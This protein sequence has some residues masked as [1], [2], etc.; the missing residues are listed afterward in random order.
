MAFNSSRV[1]DGSA[2]NNIWTWQQ[3]SP[4]KPRRTGLRGELLASRGSRERG[5]YAGNNVVYEDT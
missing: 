1:S 4:N 5:E 3:M 2:K